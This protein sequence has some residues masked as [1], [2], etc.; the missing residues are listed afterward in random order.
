MKSKLN[1]ILLFLIS[2]FGCQESNSQ[3]KVIDN[4]PNDECEQGKIDAEIDIKKNNLG[5]YFYGHPNPRFN[6]W[7]RLISEE[8]K[9]SI[10]GGGDIVE[11]KGEC[12]NQVMNEKIKEK[13]GKD[14]FERVEIKLD[15]LY[16][17]GLGDREPIF[18]GGDSKLM[19]YLYCNLDNELISNNEEEIPIIVVQILI[20]KEG[21]VHKQKILFKNK[22]AKSDNKYEKNVI[23]II[24]NMPNWIPGIE[25]KK[26]IDF[27]YNLPIKFGQKI[28]KEHCG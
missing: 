4:I 18:E 3:I 26:R 7:L 20:D 27:R 6:T 22:F 11:E 16:E 10:K 23:Q 13:F 1:L 24:D 8:Y 5:L 19:N 17:I 9:L 2:F 28:K 12:Y 21:V 15:S 14:A 25:N